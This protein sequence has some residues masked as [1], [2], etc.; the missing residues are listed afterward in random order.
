[1]HAEVPL[2]GPSIVIPFAG[3]CALESG[4]EEN[5]PPSS[6]TGGRMPA[7]HGAS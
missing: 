6:C 7:W 4:S 2:Q 5:H 3:M 1:M